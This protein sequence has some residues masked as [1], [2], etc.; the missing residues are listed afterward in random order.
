[1][2]GG[3]VGGKCGEGKTET[4]ERRQREPGLV[5]KIKKNIILK[6]KFKNEKKNNLLP[7]LQ[8]PSFFSVNQ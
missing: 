3:G 8:L 7:S 5:Y 1:M 2:D 6:N 4:E